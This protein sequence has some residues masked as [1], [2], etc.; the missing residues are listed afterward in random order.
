MPA[1]VPEFLLLW[2]EEQ[3]RRHLRVRA[4][5]LLLLRQRELPIDD[6]SSSLL[7]LCHSRL[8]LSDGT[9][10]SHRHAT[11]R[12][13]PAGERS[14]TGQFLDAEADRTL[15]GPGAVVQ[16]RQQVRRRAVAGA[17]AANGLAV[18]RQHHLPGRPPG[19]WCAPTHAPTARSTAAGST[20]VST[21]QIV[22]RSG[23]GPGRPSGARSRG[24]ASAAHSA[25]A[26]YDLAPASIAHTADLGLPEGPPNAP[27]RGPTPART[28]ENQP[29]LPRSGN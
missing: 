6:G 24:G 4:W 18:H 29:A 17:G 26:A 15:W 2:S 13:V 25:I 12:L 22:A 23:T 14:G 28:P 1:R 3:R 20:V 9:R 16:A 19:R 5:C 10:S 7:S 11:T 27:G 8:L 21:R